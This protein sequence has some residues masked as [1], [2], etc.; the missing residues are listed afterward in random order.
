M[1]IQESTSQFL[2]EIGGK[3]SANTQ[4]SY[5]NGIKVLNKYF[6]SENL[7]P[8]DDAGCLTTNLLIGFPAF[9]ARKKYSKKTVGLYTSSVRS[10]YK[11]LIIHEVLDPSQRDV[12]RFDMVCTDANQKREVKLPRW[13]N[14]DDVDKMI[15]AVKIMN[16]PSPRIERDV[17]V[18]E[19]LASTGCRNA[20]IC[21]LKVKDVDIKNRSAIVTGKGDKERQVFFS[22]NAQGALLAYWKERGHFYQD[23]YVFCRHD[24]GAGK[25]MKKL[26]TATIRSIV[27][28]VAKIAG[29][30][31]FTPHYF[32]HAFAIKALR[33]TGNLA[34]VQDLLG[35]ADP[36]ATRVYAKIY[37]DEL[38]DAHHRI[39]D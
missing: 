26:T 16:E 10:F 27:K 33:E 17:A 24:K 29:I 23:A 1:N 12:L 39:F 18:I 30:K 25:K 6:K 32:R 38:R 31:N 9:L 19:F 7:S 2:R 21:N 36:A 20:E 22:T 11:W 28:D 13:P 5:G 8:T 15:D 34:L 37:P 4:R 14:K 3:R 35:H